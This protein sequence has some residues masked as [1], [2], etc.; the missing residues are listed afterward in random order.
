M[1]DFQRHG[2]AVAHRERLRRELVHGKHEEVRDLAEMNVCRDPGGKAALQ[3]L[4]LAV[5]ELERLLR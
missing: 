2:A 4:R 1:S 3:D 5:D